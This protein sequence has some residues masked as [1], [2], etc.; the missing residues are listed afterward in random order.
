MG[1]HDTPAGEDFCEDLV[2]V[3]P[4]SVYPDGLEEISTDEETFCIIELKHVEELALA[5]IVVAL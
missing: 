1:T 2:G 3:L 5:A 4:L